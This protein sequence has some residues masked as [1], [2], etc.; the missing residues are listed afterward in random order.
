MAVFHRW[1]TKQAGQG[2]AGTAGCGVDLSN[3]T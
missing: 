2:P 1:N 3:P